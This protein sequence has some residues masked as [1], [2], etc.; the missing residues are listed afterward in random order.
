MVKRNSVSSVILY[1]SAPSATGRKKR[2]AIQGGKD[3]QQMGGSSGEYL[4][5]TV[6]GS[7]LGHMYLL[8]CFC[9]LA[10][11]RYFR[12]RADGFSCKVITFS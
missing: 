3:N 11:P 10:L 5:P 9:F 4:I 8:S 2:K 6:K 12:L 1:S 7:S